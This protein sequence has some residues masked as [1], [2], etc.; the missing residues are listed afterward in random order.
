MG[1]Q[2]TG[3]QF[4]STEVG[5]DIVG[6]ARGAGI[7]QGAWAADES[8]FGEPVDL[9]LREDGPWLMAVA[10][11]ARSR[12]TPPNATYHIFVISSFVGFWGRTLT[13]TTLSHRS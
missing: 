5:A 9:T 4:T 6:M 11:T 2:I 10:S 1:Y 13:D 8:G 12:R 3:V 7:A